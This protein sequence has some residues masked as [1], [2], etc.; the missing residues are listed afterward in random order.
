M[1]TS[2]LPGLVE[3]LQIE[4]QSPAGTRAA[5][6]NRPDF[7]QRRRRIEADAEH[8][9]RRLRPRAAGIVDGRQ[10]RRRFLRS[11]SRCRKPARPRQRKAR[12]RISSIGSCRI[13]IRAAARKWS[14]TA[15]PIGIVGGLHPRLL[16]AL[17]LDEDIQ[18]F[19]LD[20]ASVTAG[21]VPKAQPISRFPSVRRDIAVVVPDS[22]PYAS[23]EATAR[24]ALGTALADL[25]VFDQYQG[26]NLGSGVKSLAIGLILQDDSRTLTDQDADSFVAKAVT[27]LEQECH[28]RLRG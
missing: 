27:A 25:L 23:I 26:P 7:Q 17:D 11:E 4:P 24:R 2:L 20:V 19:E 15:N 28:A 21:T 3:I 12:D 9:R 13:C 8:R 6:R 14:S 10:A 22:T 5:V 18:V 16:K 1:R